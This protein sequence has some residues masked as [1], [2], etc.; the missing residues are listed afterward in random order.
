M[1]A[2]VVLWRWRSQFMRMLLVAAVLLIAGAIK[3]SGFT[4]L[5]L[6]VDSPDVDLV[7]PITD[8]LTPGDP[9]TGRLNLSDPENIE[10]TVVYDPV[11]GQYVVQSSVGG[12]FDYRPPMSMSLEE[13]L[14]YDMERSMDNYW[15][16]RVEQDSESAQKQLIPKI[17]VRGEAFDR[18]FGLPQ[19]ARA[20][21]DRP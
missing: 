11:T 20:A 4:G 6:Q 2:K 1:K 12:S 9:G 19:S 13:Y 14:E 21:T 18:I 3:A 10:N 16:D 8:P 15:L 7:W 5:I 17:K